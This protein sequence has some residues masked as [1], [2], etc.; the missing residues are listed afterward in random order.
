MNKRHNNPLRN[1]ILGLAAA[2][3]IVLAAPA[4][5]DHHGHMLDRLDQKLELNDEQREQ[6][7][8]LIEAHRDQMR[9][10]RETRREGDSQRGERRGQWR[11]GRM[12]LHEEIRAVLSEEQVEQFDALH[13]RK[14]RKHKRGEGGR[15]GYGMQALDLS[16]EQR[17]AMRELMRE[18][19][20][21]REAVRDGMREILDDEQIARLEEMR[22][23]RGDKEG[24]QRRQR[25]NG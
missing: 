19:R 2:G 3:A 4:M 6:I 1:L 21:D 16:D 14:G 25:N 18:N 20:G 8:N 11:E 5:A 9:S 23:Q 10:Q 7:G 22:A 15:H 13:E 17:Q 12:A 24:K